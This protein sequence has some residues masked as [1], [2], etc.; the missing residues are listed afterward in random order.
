[1]SAAKRFN[2]TASV[3]LTTRIEN[4]M[5]SRHIAQQTLSFVTAK[6]T[7]Q[8]TLQ[9]MELPEYAIRLVLPEMHGKSNQ[10]EHHYAIGQVS[11]AFQPNQQDNIL[12]A[13]GDIRIEIADRDAHDAAVAI[14]YEF[15][16]TGDADPASTASHAVE[17]AIIYEST[18]TQDGTVLIS[19]IWQG[20]SILARAERY[21]PDVSCLPS[22]AD[23]E[24]DVLAQTV[25]GLSNPMPIEGAHPM[26]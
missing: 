8:Q 12:Q 6:S 19:G 23:P 17:E 3:P 7:L 15:V 10:G 20:G 9:L 25:R 24:D 26:A 18:V 1:M 11:A 13:I 4:I 16:A 21:I 22:T 5:R 14:R 2:R